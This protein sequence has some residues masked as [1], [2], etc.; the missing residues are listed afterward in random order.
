MNLRWWMLQPCQARGVQKNR[1]STGEN[2]HTIRYHASNEWRLVKDWV[3]LGQQYP[4][5]STGEWCLLARSAGCYR[6]KWLSTREPQNAARIWSP[7][8][9]QSTRSRPEATTP[10]GPNINLKICS[11]DAMADPGGTGAPLR[12]TSPTAEPEI[13]LKPNATQTSRDRC[14]ACIRISHKHAVTI[15]M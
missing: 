1:P 6:R 7:S 13:F 9:T 11:S 10:G 15:A 3:N 2:P 5:G 14:A 8:G 4:G 12:R